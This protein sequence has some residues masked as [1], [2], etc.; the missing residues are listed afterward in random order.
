MIIDK[1]GPA[2]VTL[3]SSVKRKKYQLKDKSYK[4]QRYLER[5]PNS[6]SKWSY[7]FTK[8]GTLHHGDRVILYVSAEGITYYM[9]RYANEEEA[10]LILG[11]I[12]KRFI[13]PRKETTKKS[14]QW[15]IIE[16]NNLYGPYKY[17]NEAE[18]N[19]RRM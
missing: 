1:L 15:W 3:G 10:K 2:I 17:R 9:G 18:I 12:T 11:E 6:C 4:R 19:S 16:G 13:Q 5:L 8:V 7:Y 14:K